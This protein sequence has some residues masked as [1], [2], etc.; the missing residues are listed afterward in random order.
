MLKAQSCSGCRSFAASR[1]DEVEQRGDVPVRIGP[2]GSF[3][4][5]KDGVQRCLGCG[6]AT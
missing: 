6:L 3:F 5:P 4:G 2:A 1:G